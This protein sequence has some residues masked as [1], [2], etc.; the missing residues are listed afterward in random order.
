MYQLTFRFTEKPT[1]APRIMF[2]SKD[3]W[4][5]E[6]G[7][8]RLYCEALIGEC[9]TRPRD[10]VALTHAL[11][12][13]TITS[14]MFTQDDRTWRTPAATSGGGKCGPTTQWE[15]CCPRR[16]KSRPFGEP[17]VHQYHLLSYCVK[18]PF[19]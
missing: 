12:S 6:G 1:D 7:E 13:Q 9:T 16:L 14:T 2:I 15:T 4:V 17:A 5:E 18:L 8:L 11:T 10:Y 19:L 3:Q